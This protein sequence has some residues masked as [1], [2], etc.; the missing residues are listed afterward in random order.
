MS[1]FAVSIV[2][3]DRPGIVAAVTAVFAERGCNLQD[4]S[5]TV[6]NGHLAMTLVVEA[7]F[8]L[9]AEALQGALAGTTEAMQLTAIVQTVA[10]DAPGAP[11]GERYS[12]AVYGSD[13]PGIVHAI[14]QVLAS[15]SINIDDLSTR[16]VGGA[17][18]PVYVMALELTIPSACD[19]EALAAR[20]DVL[21]SELDVSCNLHR[22]E[23]DV[24]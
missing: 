9:H 11:R 6:L 8:D 12:M 22:A 17:E 13:H 3:L 1:R 10:D 24:L 18:R 2:G 14:A 7:P 16:V 5:M 19:P 4:C 23:T 15:E 20:L 21:A